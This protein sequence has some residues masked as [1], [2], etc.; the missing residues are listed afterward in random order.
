MLKNR[1]KTVQTSPADN[2]S[3]KPHTTVYLFA[4]SSGSEL[5]VYNN[6]LLVKND[7]YANGISWISS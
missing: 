2:T 3:A 7:T 4:S 6:I 1:K 5:N